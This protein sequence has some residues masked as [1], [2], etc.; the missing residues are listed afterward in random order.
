MSTGSISLSTITLISKTANYYYVLYAG[1]KYNFHEIYRWLNLGCILSP[2][3]QQFHHN[4]VLSVFVR[5][6]LRPTLKKTGNSTGSI[7]VDYVLLFS[8]T[9]YLFVAYKYNTA[10]PIKINN[11]ISLVRCD[12]AKL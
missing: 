11:L 7:N 3:Q 9:R 5:L 8:F 6:V 1:Q 12:Q 2:Q 10:T 4:M